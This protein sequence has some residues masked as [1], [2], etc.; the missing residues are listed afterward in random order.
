MTEEWR[1]LAN[2]DYEVSSL[3][4]VRSLSRERFLKQYDLNGYRRV[5]FG[6]KGESVHRLVL[7]AFVGPC[8]EGLEAAHLDGCRNNNVI[9]NL[10][11]VTRK[12]NHSHKKLHGT[13]QIGERNGQS[14]LTQDQ[15]DEIIRLKGTARAKDICGGFGVHYTT[16]GLIW[17]GQR[18]NYRE[19]QDLN[20]QLAKAQAEI[21]RLRE[22][23]EGALRD[24]LKEQGC[25]V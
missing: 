7:E 22:A 9:T 25:D 8:P 1:P 24:F 21:E 5:S 6:G 4:R 18:W 19:R 16:I 17:R 13:E 11:W 2:P 23:L 14:K 3:G 10:K 12:E 20:D 15:V